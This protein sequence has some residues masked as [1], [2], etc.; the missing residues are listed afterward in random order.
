[1][2]FARALAIKLHC[3]DI[4]GRKE[5]GARREHDSANRAYNAHTHVTCVYTMY[6]TRIPYVGSSYTQSTM[7]SVSCYARVA[8][9]SYSLFSSVS[10]S[11]F[12][13]S[14]CAT[15]SLEREHENTRIQMHTDAFCLT[16]SILLM[17]FGRGRRGEVQTERKNGSKRRWFSSRVFSLE[18]ER[19]RDSYVY[20]SQVRIIHRVFVLRKKFSLDC[21]SRLIAQFTCSFDNIMI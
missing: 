15:S 19:F 18:K 11:Q 5:R 4:G 9:S 2:R 21:R 10:S 17:D 14:G 6:Y 8:A 7:Y 3:F 13:L 1:M 12:P 16:C 20:D